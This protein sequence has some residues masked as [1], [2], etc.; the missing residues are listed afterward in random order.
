MT[1]VAP[2]A[3]AA[4]N[5]QLNSFERRLTKVETVVTTT[6][7]HL[8]TKADVKSAMNTHL[9]WM[10]GLFVGLATLFYNVQNRM[11]DR[12]TQRMDRIEH[13]S[14]QRFEELKRLIVQSKTAPPAAESISP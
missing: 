1:T 8:A 3:L 2:D 9:Y 6:T 10:I 11:E 5:Q 12:L 14:E 7:P 4:Y 13:R